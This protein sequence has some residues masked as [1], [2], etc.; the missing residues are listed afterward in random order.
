MVYLLHFAQPYRHARH[1]LGSTDNLERRL[2]EH[3][4]G[5]GARL[6]EVITEAGIDFTLARTWSG[7]RALERQLKNRKEAPRLCPLCRVQLTLF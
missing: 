4:S 7:G 3:R 5:A 1:Y 2:Q 6:L